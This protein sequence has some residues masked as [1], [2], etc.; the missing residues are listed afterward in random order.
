MTHQEYM[1]G[2]LAWTDESAAEVLR[3]VR[4]CTDCRRDQRAARDAIADLVPQG[5]S[6]LEVAV[7]IGSVA[8]I[9]A[10]LA[11]GLVPAP[12]GQPRARHSARYRIVGDAAGV[13]AQTPEGPVVVAGAAGAG[14]ATEKEVSR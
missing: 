7:R 8:A 4:R 1:S 9:L 5:R 13:V 2:A 10:L 3:H 11:A 12:N 14:H 6:R